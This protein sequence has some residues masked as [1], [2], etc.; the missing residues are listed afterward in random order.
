MPIFI[1]VTS[2]RTRRTFPILTTVA[3]LTAAVIAVR[4]QAS[5]TIWGDLTYVVVV[6]IGAG[7]AVV[8]RRRQAGASRSAWT[9]LALGL[10]LSALGDVAAEYLHVVNGV[11]P[12]ISVADLG[13]LGSYFALAAGLLRLLHDE[14][15]RRVNLDAL[16]DG[17]AVFVMALIVVWYISIAPVLGDHS[18]SQGVRFVWAVYPIC[19]AVLLALVARAA[20]GRL[21]T[22]TSG[23]LLIGGVL[24]WLASDLGY[25][26][27]AGEDQLATLLDV[28]WMLG[29]LLMGT[30]AWTGG[31]R[32]HRP[33]TSADEIGK[34]RVALAILPMLAP[35]ILA[36]IATLQNRPVN[37]Y[38]HVAAT[39]VLG[40]LAFTRAARLLSEKAAVRARLVASERYYQ[41]LADNSSDA[42]LLISAEGR[43]LNDPTRA[44]QLL[45]FD[46]S[47]DE[48][49]GRLEAAVVDIERVRALFTKVAADPSQPAIDEI[50][51]RHEDGRSV[52]IAVRLR[53]LLDDPDVGALVA[54]LQEITDR[55]RAEADLLHQALHDSLTGLANR[56][57]LRDRVEHSLQQGARSG[58]TSALIYL[59]LDGF[60]QVNDSLGHD[61]GDQ[62]LFETAQRISRVVR[63]GDTVARLGGDEFAILVEDCVDPQR[64]A[65]RVADRVLA[66]LTVPVRIGLHTA[67]VSASVGIAVA[68]ETCSATSLLRD[69]DVAMYR[70]K[71][72]GRGHWV[73]FHPAMRV[74]AVERR[75]IENDIVTALDDGQLDLEY[76]P[77]IE[78]ATGRITGFEAL[79]RWHHPTLGLVPP[80]TFVPIAEETG[81]ILPIGRWVVREACQ[82]AV[83]W[84]REFGEPI[85][86]AVNV[87][88]R[89]LV[90][91]AVIADVAE[92]IAFSGIDPNALVLELTETALVDDILAVTERL[93]ELRG[94]GVRI[95]VDDFGTGYSSLSHLRQFPVD[96]LK[97]DRSFI[98]TITE[99]SVPG[100]AGGL[101]DL[102]RTLGL[103]TVAE[104]IETIAQLDWLRAQNCQMG[105]GYLFDEALSADDARQRLAHQVRS[106]APA[107]R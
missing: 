69:A 4:V 106:T 51:L 101:L 100:I 104:G 37:P 72:R 71:N 70:A 77:V 11:W 102:A 47:L 85:T 82:A 12:E 8:G 93:N 94:L 45:G 97:I 23:S 86:M 6:V 53:N 87:S 90:S 3:A 76:Q 74:E 34:G 17:G 65:A 36:L 66:A 107:A 95:A 38:V 9:M 26:Q 81:L 89:Q 48:F 79:L 60:K 22:T 61:V 30:A 59:D 40:F 56:T 2:D 52:W 80:E 73:M 91:V 7:L 57:L 32:L 50:E 83:R 10:S 88:V 43:F 28:G 41:A 16:I 96:I 103:E 67:T 15:N 31:Q 33:A 98:M 25:M 92:A 54:N 42:F 19:D 46:S 24:F 18:V 62:F 29:A 105:Q 5:G 39:A 55:K 99:T 27:L 49:R 75:Q 63:S 13:W 21:T 68:D 35:S 58:L 78:L 14:T 1:L 20:I 64:D 44:S 84:Q